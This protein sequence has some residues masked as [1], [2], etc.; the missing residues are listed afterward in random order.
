MADITMCGDKEC[1]KKES[2]YRWTA[3]VNTWG[4]SFFI[5]SPRVEE[6]CEY[7]WNNKEE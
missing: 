1:P 3:P 4:Q 6:E 7:F 2:C 5:E